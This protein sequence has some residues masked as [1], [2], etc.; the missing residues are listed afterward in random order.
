MSITAIKKRI[1]IFYDDKGEQIARK[2]FSKTANTITYGNRSFNVFHDKASTTLIKRWYWN[3]EQY[4]YN[5][6]NPNPFMLN[7]KCEPILDSENY[8]IQ[9]NTK[10]ARDLNDLS[11]KGFNLDLKTILIGLGIIAVAYL[12]LSGGIKLK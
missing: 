9:L 7:K 3:V 1:A 12:L 6:N 5:I 8:N 11:K 2:G 10:V 4:H